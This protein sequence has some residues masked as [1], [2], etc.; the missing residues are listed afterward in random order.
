M[1]KYGQ[2]GNIERRD[3]TMQLIYQLRR[4][5]K[6]KKVETIKAFMY[7]Q[8]LQILNRCTCL[9]LEICFEIYV[10]AYPPKE[11]KVLYMVTKEIRRFAFNLKYKTR[12]ESNP[13]QLVEN[14]LSTNIIR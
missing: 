12:L 1:A 9:L 5:K 6:Y 13:N 2:E 3:I 14:L 10:L 8:R 4:G 11:Q 7:L